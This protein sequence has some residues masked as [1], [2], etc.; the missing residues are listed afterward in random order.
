MPACA[1]MTSGGIQVPCHARAGLPPRSQGVGI[2]I[3]N[4]LYTELLPPIN[5][6][7]V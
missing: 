3:F 7:G 5:L 4:K 6:E 1:G 2:P